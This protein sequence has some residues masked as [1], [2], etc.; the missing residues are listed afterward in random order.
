[1]PKSKTTT[2][3]TGGQQYRKESKEERKARLK[4]QQEAREFCQRVL[5]S[6]GGLLLFL[7]IGFAVYVRSVPP[8]VTSQPMAP[9][10]TANPNLEEFQQPVTNEASEELKSEANLQEPEVRTKEEETIEL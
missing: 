8:K 2:S 5:P 1:M 10:D 4:S 7:L 9:T 3:K 6:I